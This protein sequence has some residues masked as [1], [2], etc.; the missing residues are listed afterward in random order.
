MLGKRSR[1]ETEWRI[2]A[3]TM[4][5]AAGFWLAHA[6]L[7]WRF[8]YGGRFWDVL[9]THVPAHDIVVRLIGVGMI[10]VL[11]VLLAGIQRRQN[12]IMRD[13]LHSEAMFRGVFE[14]IPS[15]MALIDIHSQRFLKVNSSLE[16]ILGYSGT[17]LKGMTIQDVTPPEDWRKEAPRIQAYFRRSTEPFEYQKRYIRKDGSIRW[18]LVTGEILPPELSAKNKTALAVINDITENLE[19][20][21]R[22]RESESRFRTMAET[23]PLG[24]QEIDR[25]G[26]IEWVNPAYCNMYRCRPQDAVGT[27][28]WDWV[29]DKAALRKLYF[30]LMTENPPPTTWMGKNLLGESALIDVRVDWDYRRDAEGRVTGAVAVI[31]DVTEEKRMQL[32]LHQ[33]RR[34]EAVGRLAGGVAHDLNNLLTPILGYAGMLREEIGPDNANREALDQ[35]FH[36][37]SRSRDL[38]RQ[39]LAFGRRQTMEFTRLDLNEVIRGVEGILRRTIRENVRIHYD[40][41]TRPVFIRADATQLEQVLTNLA[42]NAQDAMPNGGDLT[43]ET[44]SVELDAEYI[45]THPVVKPGRYARLTV[46]DTGVGMDEETRERIFDPFFTTKEDS[47]GTGLGLATIYGAVKQHGGYIWVYSERGVGSTF[48]LYFPLQDFQ[49]APP[50]PSRP[51]REESADLSGSESVMVVEDDAM[52]RRLAAGMLR[53]LGY[54]VITAASGEECLQKFLTRKDP[55]DLLLTDVVM[56]GMD[57]GTLYERLRVDH[58]ELKVVFMSGYTDNVMA[59]NG[60]LQKEADFLQKPFT[61]QALGECIR[62]ALDEKTKAEDLNKE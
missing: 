1:V 33:A 18:V 36:A 44:T 26:R 32:L 37:G 9:I 8:F 23:V 52:V 58:P 14:N 5:L 42:V 19:V 25:Q 56:P 17:E 6:L 35:I 3:W 41:D 57:G 48:K 7:H 2:I 10:L 40:L 20:M 61:I 29:P 59:R 11:G 28:I 34:M 51:R 45:R 38:V 49:A 55:V 50:V 62:C 4:L 21:E 16:A 30:K 31:A 39:L 46:S 53:R 12:V 22:L 54:S 43:M 13:L 47:K 15:G 60:L 27:H 24:I